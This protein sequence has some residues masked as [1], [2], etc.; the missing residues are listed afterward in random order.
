MPALWT[1]QSAGP[2]KQP[3]REERGQEGSL[4]G[5]QPESQEDHGA[6]GI[7]EARGSSWGTNA[8]QRSFSKLVG[9]VLV[10]TITKKKLEAICR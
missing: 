10:M 8:C 6:L 9:T 2:R 4:V 5:G 1:V 3:E 7:S